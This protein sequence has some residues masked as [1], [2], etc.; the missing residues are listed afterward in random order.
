MMKPLPWWLT[1]L[2]FCLALTGAV[3]PVNAQAPDSIEDGAQAAAPTAMCI[4]WNIASQ[5]QYRASGGGYGTLNFVQD[6]SGNL[7]GTW[8][9]VA[10]GSNGS[11][12]G[13]ISGASLVWGDQPSGEN[14]QATLNPDGTKMAG[15]YSGTNYNGTWEATGAATCLKWQQQPAAGTARAVVRWGSYTYYVTIHS[16]MAGQIAAPVQTS[17]PPTI[18]FLGP[19]PLDI[20]VVIYTNS[21]PG[22]L[23][24]VQRVNGGARET[25]GSLP[26]SGTTADGGARYQGRVVVNPKG[27]IG[28][29]GRETHDVY[30]VDP[31]DNSERLIATV[32]MFLIDPSGY[33]YNSST[34][35]RIEGATVSCFKKEGT[36]WVLW[37]AGQYLQT[38]PQMSDVEGRYGWEVEQGTY[39]VRVSKP[40]YRDAQSA[41]LVIPPPRTDVNIGLQPVACSHLSLTG[42]WTADSGGIATTEFRRGQTVQIHIPVASTATSDVQATVSWLVNDRDGTRIDALSGAAAYAVAAFGAEVIVVKRIPLN[43]AEGTYTV[44]ASLTHEEQTSLKATGFLVA[45]STGLYLPL[46]TRAAGGISGRVTYQGSAA[47]GIALNLRFYN[48]TAWSTAATTTT[49]GS[50]R[51]LFTG[52][53]ALAA[54]QKYYVRFGPNTTNATYLSS[55]YGPDIPAYT[56][57]SQIAGGDFDIANVVLLSPAPGATVSLPALFTWQRRQLAGD[58]YRW[59]V[60]DLTT[61]DTWW[62]EDLGD[63]GAFNVTGLPS[64]V[65]R[66]Q[67]YGWY[68]QVYRGPDSYGTSFYY[69]QVTFAAG[70][71]AADLGVPDREQVAR[72]GSA[73]PRPLEER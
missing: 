72:D 70:M 51:Y 22:Q 53:P 11:L 45:G 66:G 44:I 33:I 63:V 38:N 43:L 71:G 12:T 64:E 3:P 54:G 15:P 48:G 26:R 61:S 13:R 59:L 55:W 60:F 14:F 42:V 4:A 32:V 39:Q 58:T 29:G 62:T 9:N 27:P 68:V 23:Q 69:R 17:A 34:N 57:S 20:E 56:G 18:F 35:A 16:G 50:G 6:A 5:W 8:H 46:I 21:P 24:V 41:S 2:A 19:T 52:I 73:G 1:A 65:V 30:V 31:T 67:P 49:D 10:Q 28:V 36:N 37:D 25:I 7:T 47:A 40:C